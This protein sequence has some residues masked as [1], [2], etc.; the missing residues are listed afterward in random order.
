MPQL[1]ATPSTIYA[2]INNFFKKSLQKIW[3]NGKWGVYLAARKDNN[4]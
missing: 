2:Q 4:N 1:F 3:R